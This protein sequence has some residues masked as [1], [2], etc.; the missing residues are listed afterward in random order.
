[1]LFLFELPAWSGKCLAA[2]AFGLFLSQDTTRP[3][4]ETNQQQEQRRLVVLLVGYAMHL[5]VNTACLTE[6][7]KKAGLQSRFLTS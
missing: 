5:P 2:S 6:L 3:L 4:L 1:M 7:Q